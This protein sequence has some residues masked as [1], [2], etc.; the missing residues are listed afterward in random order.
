MR[1]LIAAIPIALIA[2]IALVAQPVSAQ[3]QSLAAVFHGAEFTGHFI[4]VIAATL[5]ALVA[6]VATVALSPRRRCRAEARRE[7]RTMAGA[8]P[9]SEG[10]PPVTARNAMHPRRVLILMVGMFLACSLGNGLPVDEVY[11]RGDEKIV[12][13]SAREAD[14]SD[15]DMTVSATYELEEDGR[16][17]LEIPVYGTTQVVH[18]NV[19]DLGLQE[20]GSDGALGKTLFTRENVGCAAI[21]DSFRR[22]RGSQPSRE[23]MAYRKVGYAVDVNDR[24]LR[25]DRL[26]GVWWDLTGV[27]E[28]YWIAV[29][30]HDE[31]SMHYRYASHDSELRGYVNLDEGELEA[32]WEGM[33]ADAAAERQR[34]AEE[35]AA[36]RARAAAAAAAEAQRGRELVAESKVRRQ[37]YGTFVLIEKDAWGREPDQHFTVEVTD[38]AITGLKP[39]EHYVEV[40]GN[41]A[42][43][44]WYCQVTSVD[45]LD[46]ARHGV[47]FRGY[48]QTRLRTYRN[49]LQE[50]DGNI[51]RGQWT[52]GS[53]QGNEEFAETVTRAFEQWKAKFGEVKSEFSCQLQG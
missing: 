50:W 24:R 21:E 38:V 12:I 20:V 25:G 32:W 51:L 14:Y 41:A 33:Q 53:L 1:H 34:R 10:N 8:A 44:W 29:A 47:R 37:T 6:I 23:Y 9:R 36:E 42:D 19:T 5:I 26:P 46:S 39:K 22:L 18:Y 43:S 17:R 35:A 16:V 4:N 2:L 15:G 45:D 3:E 7:A 30:G 52:T 31:C 40:T 49:G 28:E 13:R 48:K 27:P 11:E